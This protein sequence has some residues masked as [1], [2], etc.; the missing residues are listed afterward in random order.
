MRGRKDKAKAKDI[1]FNE[2]NSK[3]KIILRSGTI[4][5]RKSIPNDMTIDLINHGFDLMVIYDIFSP[6]RLMSRVS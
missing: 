1:S 5:T 2:S 3:L 4:N 6:P